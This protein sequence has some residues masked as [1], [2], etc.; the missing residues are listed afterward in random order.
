VRF[1][2]GTIP[3]MGKK[4]QADSLGRLRTRSRKSRQ[5]GGFAGVANTTVQVVTN[6]AFRL[7]IEQFLEATAAKLALH[8]AYREISGR[9]GVKYPWVERFLQWLPTVFYTFLLVSTQPFQN[10][11]IGAVAASFLRYVD[12][13]IQSKRDE[14][15]TEGVTPAPVVTLP[16]PVPTPPEPVAPPMA[17]ELQTLL[18]SKLKSTKTTTKSTKSKAVKKVTK[19]NAAVKS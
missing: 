5:V 2:R 11:V 8:Y 10:P 12:N 6:P 18:T 4:P 13:Y 19:S 17:P 7:A 15:N 14:V 9:T 16:V 1:L 3:H